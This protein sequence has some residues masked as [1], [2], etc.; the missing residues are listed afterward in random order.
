MI[1]HGRWSPDSSVLPA[2]GI[3]TVEWTGPMKPTA[4]DLGINPRPRRNSARP[5]AAP[6]A[7]WA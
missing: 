7:A 6:S 1:S 3:G 4:N 5:L 2:S